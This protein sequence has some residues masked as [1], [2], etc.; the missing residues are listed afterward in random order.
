MIEKDISCYSKFFTEYTEL[1]VQENRNLRIA[2]L[3]GSV[4][5]NSKAAISGVSARVYKAGVWGFSSNPDITDEAVMKV[6]KSA[7]DNSIFLDSRERRDKTG[8]TE[9]KALS[10]NDFSTKKKRKN[11]ME[12]IEFI[13]GVDTYITKNFSGIN[14]RVIALSCL[15][16]EKTLI[17]SDGSSAYSMMPRSIIQIVLTVLK[18]GE[19]VELYDVYGG[20]GQ[21]EDHFSSHNV[22]CEKIDAQYE[23]LMKKAE[24]VF[25]S[26]GLCDCILDA[27]LAGILSHESIGHTTEADLVL[28]GSVA[29]DYLNKEVASP[30]VTLVD[31]ANT[32]NGDLCPIPVFVDDEGTK[33]EDV[34][35]IEKGILK[36]F[37]HNKESANHFNTVATGNARAFNF[38]DEPIIRMRNTAILPGKDKLEEMISSIDNGYY[39]MTAGNGQADSTSEFMFGIV[40][41]YEIKNGK[42]GKAIKD[43]TISGVAFDVLKTVDMVSDD[44]NWQCGGMCGKKQAIPVGMG[45]P[46]LKCRLNIG[47]R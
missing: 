30:M 18:D 2:M 15:D 10:D 29:G 45:G 13:K 12:L 42:I 36:G 14:S 9:A 32:A 7:T 21:F 35:I 43:T 37:M 28:G 17:T 39:L 22:F 25:P 46:A 44:M 23:H 11:Q 33:A 4:V 47:G 31:F 41:G 16:M 19:P 27:N 8:L 3:N 6:I 40:L 20:S 5:Q 1:R 38:S 24:G 26:A 34:T